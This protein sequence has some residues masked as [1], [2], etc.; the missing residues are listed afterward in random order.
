MTFEKC[1]QSCYKTGS[2]FNDY[3]ISMGGQLI[4]D[5]ESKADKESCL[6]KNT[7]KNLK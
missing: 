7:N 6:I 1:Q 5:S 4:R 3:I 2:E